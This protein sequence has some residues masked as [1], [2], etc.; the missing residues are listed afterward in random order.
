MIDIIIPTMWVPESLYSALE[1]YL[2]CKQINRII[3][4][5][6]CR[7]KRPPAMHALLND[8]K[9]TV[10]DYG[11][12]IYVNPAWNEG[13]AASTAPLVCIAND[14]IVIQPNIFQMVIDHGIQP[15]AIVGVN[16]R[17][18]HDNYR[19]DDHID[20]QEAVVKLNYDAGKPIGGQAWAWGIC[21]FLRRSDY[22]PIPSLYQ[23]WY[24]DDY[25]AQRATAVYAINTNH[26][27]GTIS[28][29]LKRYPQKS[30]VH[31]RIVQD[32]KNLI[33]CGH[34]KNGQNWDIPKHMINQTNTL[35]YS[36]LAQEYA[37]ATTTIS[38]IF[39]NV[40]ILYDLARECRHATEMGVRT[41]NSTRALLY[42][43]VDLVSY[44]LVLNPS[45]Q[46]LFEHAGSLGKNVKYVQANVLDI[47]IEETDLLFIDTYHTYSQLTQ[48]LR[49]H[50]NKARKYIAFH[51]TYTFGLRGEDGTDNQGL[52]SAV[53]EF[54]IANPHW[55]LKI[56][57]TNNN[58][59]TVLERT[60]NNK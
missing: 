18:Q 16:L 33:R 58:G 24:G 43:D 55:R 51:D 49:L 10:I 32:S 20:T 38:D 42:A 25:L 34:F 23:V 1:I 6:N 47:T 57:K 28:E 50:G 12:N 39:E 45:V 56:Y 5:D 35:N 44:D 3:V 15:G 7:S 36:L 19:I 2:S 46:Q 29:T 9:I 4:I 59:F 53:I 52:L 13:V 37:K 30:D 11:R 60:D 14:D 26:I 48:E 22:T 41:G 40:H 17:G 31:R 8:R 27:K 21:L 54:I